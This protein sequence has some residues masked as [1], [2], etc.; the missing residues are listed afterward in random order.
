VLN[1]IIFLSLYMQNWLDSHIRMKHPEKLKS[2]Q[3]THNTVDSSECVSSFE[4]DTMSMS[5]NMAT[6]ILLLKDC[7]V[8]LT[9]C[10]PY[11]LYI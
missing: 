9:R 8:L 11:N 7:Y 3:E 2:T 6:K 1:I 5:L 4:L 10:S